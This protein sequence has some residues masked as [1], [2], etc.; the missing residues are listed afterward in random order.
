MCV[1]VISLRLI[2]SAAWRWLLC[3]LVAFCLVGSPSAA[4]EKTAVVRIGS[5]TY[6]PPW[7]D[8]AFVDETIAWLRWKLPQYDLQVSFY[9]AD[10]LQQAI[11]ERKVDLVFSNSAFYYRN[12]P[13]GLRDL[14]VLISNTARNPNA[15][16]AAAVIVRKDSPIEKLSELQGH[17]IAAVM[18][19][20]SPGI[21]EVKSE[22]LAQG[23]PADEILSNANLRPVPALQMS[24]IVEKVLNGRVDAGIVRACFLQ[25]LR[26]SGAAKNELTALR[27]INPVL[28]DGLACQHSTRAYPGW[29]AA[30]GPNLS[31][32]AA[33][34]ITAQLLAMPE[35]SWNQYWGTATDFTSTDQMM[36]ALK[37]GPYSYLREG[38][39]QH[40]WREYRSWMILAGLALVML[41]AYGLL[42]ELLVRRRT[43]QLQR[44]NAEQIRAEKR[45]QEATAKVDRLQR[46]GVVGQMSSIVAHEMKQPLSA[47]ENLSRGGE[48]L[49]EDEEPNPETLSDVF[50][51]IHEEAVRADRIVERVRSYG[52]G[53][54]E[55]VRLD[56]SEVLTRCVT[57]FQATAKGRLASVRIV[58]Q[59][60]VSLVANAVDIE[61][62]FFNLLA[63][64]A[65]SAAQS[66][67]PRV[68]VLLAVVDGY[69]VY[70]VADNGPRPS[71]EMLARL[72]EPMVETTKEHGLGLGLMI[73]KSLVESYVGRLQFYRNGASGVRAQVQIPL[74]PVTPPSQQGVSHE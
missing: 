8:G 10:Q 54:K 65:E 69:A 46:L 63:N 36:R 28:G 39:L 16:T 21:Y 24:S 38:I 35:N 29:V 66:R 11:A 20:R 13:N 60:S 50:A 15:S 62:I 42:L 40:L 25:D 58:Y 67:N 45:A 1:L 72:S 26:R 23:L 59:E 30:S 37:E 5:L 4:P 64:A 43:R 57:Q 33:R 18:T 44:T 61:L 7:Y 73:V 52:R 9:D 6:S 17:S 32:D 55:R 53:K 56:L 3:G 49:L 34:L 12:I 74:D 2:V 27:V 41:L 47:I 70:E 68:E 31:W 51:K 22:M 71:D 14:A 19:E 48:R